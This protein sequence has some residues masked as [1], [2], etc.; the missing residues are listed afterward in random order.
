MCL[1]V[2]LGSFWMI[3]RVEL[4]CYIEH[5]ARTRFRLAPMLW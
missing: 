5:C 3:L 2:V 1:A 4:H